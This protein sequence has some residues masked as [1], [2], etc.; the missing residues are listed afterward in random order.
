MKDILEIVEK[1]LGRKPRAFLKVVNRCRFKLPRVILSSPELSPTI[2][3][4]TCPYETYLISRL[5][6]DGLIKKIKADPL[7]KQKI[8]EKNKNYIIYRKNIGHSDISQEKGIDGIKDLSSIKCLHSHFAHYLATKKNPVGKI[9]AKHLLNNQK[10]A[11][12]CF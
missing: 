1:Q 10:C 2:F 6:S 5:E 3:W 7:L 9:I 11:K 8:L 4:L 12:K